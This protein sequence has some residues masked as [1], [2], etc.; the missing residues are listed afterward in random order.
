ME[1]LKRILLVDDSEHDRE[2]IVNALAANN[3]ANDVISLKDGVEA[4]DYLFRR[5]PFANR[6]KGQPAFVLL[7][8]KMPRVDGIEVLRQVKGDPTLKV[9]PIVVMS[10]S[11]VELDVFNSYRLG[12][13]AYVVKPMG[14]HEFSD[15]VS[16]VGAF[17]AELNEAPQGSVAR[18]NSDGV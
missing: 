9:I 2:L 4:L 1:L 6:V 17:W 12:A 5:G 7:D 3:L 11:R 15:S 16:R 8:L 18:P 10:S 14:F 13:N